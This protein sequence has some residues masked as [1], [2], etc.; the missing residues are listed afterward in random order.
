MAVWGCGS[1]CVVGAIVDARTGKIIP[2]PTV[3]GW[4]EVHDDFQ[5]IAFRKDSRL[6]VLS[7]ER[8]EKGDMGRHFYVLEGGRLKW[9]KTIKSDGN[10]LKTM[11]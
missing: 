5:G 3:S 4:K 2:L 1:A 7:G 11:N 9:V 8:N 6:V 10:F